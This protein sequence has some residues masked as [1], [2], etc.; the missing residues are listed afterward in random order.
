MWLWIL[1]VSLPAI[2]LRATRLLGT[3][4]VP[5]LLAWLVS[6]KPST[7]LANLPAWYCTHACRA[8]QRSPAGALGHLCNGAAAGRILDTVAFWSRGSITFPR[9]PVFLFYDLNHLSPSARQ[10]NSVVPILQH[11]N[12]GIT[13]HS[14][15]HRARQKI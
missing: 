11:Q 4:L 3:A 8:L 12:G 15:R 6:Y 1:A 9:A 10:I 14:S 5:D 7:S 2:L 13:N